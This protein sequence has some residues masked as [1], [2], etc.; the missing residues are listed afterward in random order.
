MVAAFSISGCG[1]SS[2]PKT[3]AVTASAT[4]VDGTDTLTLTATVT[5]DTNS[6]GVTWTVSGGGTLSDTTTTGATYTAPAASSSALTVTVTATSVADTT[7]TASVTITV[8]AAPAITTGALAAG[9]VGTAYTA[10]LTAKGGIAPY[11]WSLASGTLPTCLTITQSS[12]GASIGGTPTASCAGTYNITL[13][14]TDSGKPTPLTATTGTLSLTIT[15]APAITFTT[16][17]LA[18]GTYQAA[19]TAA[20]AATGG[21]G[22]LTYSLASGSLP[23]GLSLSASGAITG[24]PTAA[25]TFSFAV[26]AADAYGDA[27]TSQTYAIAVSYPAMSVTAATLPT[28]YVGLNY[29]ATTLAATG[30]TGVSANYTWALASGSTLPVGLNLSTAGAITGQPTGTPGKT[31]FTVS[32]TDTVASLSANGAFS[33]TV[34]AG[35]SI[36]TST[37]LPEG[38]AGTAYSVTLATSGGTGTGLT[39]SVTTGSSSLTAV[40]L[41]VSSAGVVSGTTPIAG[42]ASFTV[43]ATD[44]AGNTA[45]QSFSVTIGAGLTIT[46]SPTLPAGYAGAAYSTTLATSGGT[47]KGL[48]WSV[49]SGS[50]SLTAVGLSVSSAGVISGSTPIAGT[51]SFTV[52]VTDSYGNT[53]SQTFSVTIGT[54]LTITTPATLPEGYVGTAY[55]VTLQTGGGTGQGLTWTLTSGSSSLAAVGLSESGGVVSGTTPIAG[56]ASFSVKVTDSGGNTASQTFSVTIGAELTITTAATLPEGYAGTAY[57]VTLATSGGSGTGLTW[58]VTAGSSSLTAVGLSVSS[59]GVVSGTT[60]IA[61]SASF[62]VKLT[63]S[64]GNT[65][66]QTFSVTIGAGLTITTAATLPAGYAGTAYSTTLA[67]S[68]GTGTGLTWSV[69]SGSSSLTAV[70]LSVSSGG[71]LS[72]NK[73]VGGSAS[74]TVKATD[75]YGNTA[76]QTFTVTIEAAVTITSPTTLPAGTTGVSYSTTLTASGGSGTYTSWQITTGGASL[77]AIGLSLNTST[78]VISGSSPTTG[79]ASFSVAVT[80]SQSHVSAAVAFT[81]AVNNQ[82][83]VNQTTLP[84]GNVGVSYSQTLTASGGSGQSYT[85]TTTSSNLPNYGLSLSSGGVITG[86]PTQSGAPSFTAKVTDSASDTATQPLSITIYGA[87]SLPASNSLPPGYTGVSYNGSISGSGGSGSLSIAITSALSPSNGTL[88]ANVSG[89]TVN[90]T[91]TATTAT[92]ESITVQL[93]DTTTGNSISQ[94]Y[95]FTVSTPSAPTLPANT[96]PSATVGTAYDQTITATGGVGP[97]YTWTVNSTVLTNNTPLLIS[98]GISVETTGNNQ[99]TV[100]GTPTTT[101]QVQFQVNVEDNTTHLTSTAQTY[102]ITVNPAGSQVSGQFFL[103]NYCFNGNSNLPVTFTVGLYN[104]STLVQSTTTASDGTYSFTSIP[105]GT[106]SIEP[107]LAGAATLFYPTSITGLTLNTSSNNN[108]SGE[109]FNANVGF[110]VSG[111]VSYSGSQKGQTYLVVN[112]NNCGGGNGGPGTSITEA[113][114]TSGGAF[115]IRGVPPGSNTIDAWMDPLGQGLQNA[116]DPIGSVAVTVDGD[117]SNADLT[118]ADPTFTTPT[119]NPKIST[120]IPNAQGVLIEFNPSEN[121]NGEEDANQYLVQ[122]STSPTLGGGTGGGQFGTIAGSHTFTAAGHDGVWVLNNAV[123]AGSGFSFTSGQTYYFQA[124]SFDTLDTTNPHP[125]GWCNYTSTGCSG[126]S[127][128]TG[129][130]IGT[131]ACTG[132]CTAVSSSVTIPNSITINTGAPLYLGMIQLS[133]PGGNPVG[134]YV[135]EIANPQHGVNQFPQPIT[136]PSGSNYV[137]VGILDQ[138]KTGGFGAG[139]IT[140]VRNEIPASDYVTIS[141]SSQTVPGITLSAAN[142]VAIVGTQWSSNT[143]QNCG[144][145]TTSYQLDFEVDEGAKLPVAVTL[146]A[147]PNLINTGGTVALD[148]SSCS[149]CGNPKFQYSVTLPGGTPKV[150]DTYDFTVTYSDGSQ[151]TGSTVKGA[152]TG[153]DGGSTIVGPSDAPTNLAPNDNSS[154]STT[155]TFTWTDSSS[156][157]GS[158]F[159]YSFYL[160]DQTSCSGNCTI[161]QIPGQNSKANGFSSSITSIT[162]GTDPT[163]S[164]NTPS[165]G[166]LTSGDVYNWQISVQD[167]N[168]NQAQTSVWYQP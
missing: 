54:G 40:G 148:M 7:K 79:T 147:G 39:W 59:G 6:D 78:G 92:T 63:D 161:W 98:N 76:S 146:N 34:D 144:A 120:I 52:K 166:S 64:A 67:T 117:V 33:I 1:G 30:G 149:D 38:Y 51:A 31:N 66:S 4:T 108:V 16:T 157:T 12:S 134:I 109:N 84:S 141:G 44:S 107:S 116:I 150:G 42:S 99:L 165:V 5:N 89:A 126:T 138:D 103:P 17:T 125:S 83:K 154:T 118:M 133:G 43:K 101:S 85:W 119:E 97:N 142:S 121:S 105:N 164:S 87:L 22:T 60:P 8:P 115:T 24:T 13:K 55:S 15:A 96:L 128:F 160:S 20:V 94:T 14:V 25:G 10:T 93:T 158:D 29:P 27:A 135:T 21:A 91:G 152:V 168:N 106:Y 36:T 11:T 75:S 156:A 48:T 153:W 88:A 56:S 130:T 112:N 49:T 46:T 61:G 37:P 41:S 70:G 111:T 82:L 123:L 159:N 71:V 124:R 145:T 28:G 129:V 3:V 104:G 113:T 155:P 95:T 139:T 102:T 65:A 68:G 47:G 90:I 2:A 137:V 53:A 73:P 35:L 77:T 162:W 131:P 9:T 143:C 26:K 80:D 132:T 127:G 122:W 136:V 151:D 72:G 57:S 32:V 50:S 110:T 18:A 23:T 74:F 69:T 45:S 167:P 163:D 81:L 86:T 58:T 19:Y 62:S 114:L 140:N 100:S